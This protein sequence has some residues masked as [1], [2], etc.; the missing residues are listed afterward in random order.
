M[1]RSTPHYLEGAI[2][3]REVFAGIKSRTGAN[4]GDSIYFPQKEVRRFVVGSGRHGI[5]LTV[6]DFYSGKDLESFLKPYIGVWKEQGFDGFGTWH[7]KG[8]IYIDPFTACT[9]LLQAHKL[10]R[11]NDE[12]CFWDSKKGIEVKTQR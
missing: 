2:F 12:I 7:H 6:K 1:K 3:S 11:I 4:G 5:Q 8:T 10:S 9:T